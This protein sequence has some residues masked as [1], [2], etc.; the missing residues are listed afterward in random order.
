MLG[1]LEEKELKE[2]DEGVWKRWEEYITE[3]K[4]EMDELGVPYMTI[5]TEKT[6][7]TFTRDEEN[8]KKIL[9]FIQDI[10][11]ELPSYFTQPQ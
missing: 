5:P 11:T 4:R 3:Q 9:V 1:E 7:E 8:R 6:T 10:I 2:F